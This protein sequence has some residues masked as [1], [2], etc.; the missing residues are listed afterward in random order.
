MLCI[1]ITLARPCE[2]LLVYYASPRGKGGS[3]VHHWSSR[4]PRLPRLSYECRPYPTPNPLF[5]KKPK[6][7]KTVVQIAAADILP[8]GSPHQDQ[9]VNV[10]ADSEDRS[11]GRFFPFLREAQNVIWPQRPPLAPRTGANTPFPCEGPLF[12][13]ISV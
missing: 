2:L 9:Y 6:N 13:F 12:H 10:Q 1:V 7:N 4:N 5:G 11:Q 8:T 3:Y